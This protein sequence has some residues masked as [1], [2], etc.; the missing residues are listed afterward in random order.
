M[1]FSWSQ[2]VGRILVT[3]PAKGFHGCWTYPA[4]KNLD[5]NGVVYPVDE[6]SSSPLSMSTGAF[7]AMITVPTVVIIGTVAAITSYCYAKSDEKR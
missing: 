4:Y 6:I 3:N 1:T 5:G 2:M 7:V